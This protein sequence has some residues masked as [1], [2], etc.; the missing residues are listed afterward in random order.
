MANS[1][2][3]YSTLS[4]VRRVASALLAF[5]AFLHYNEIVRLRYCDLLI[6][7]KNMDV[8]IISSKTDQ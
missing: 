1:L 2:S 3:S 8:R 7:E 4:D 5:A 6:A